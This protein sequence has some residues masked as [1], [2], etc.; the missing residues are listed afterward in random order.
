MTEKNI[1][2][3][4][5]SGN[6]KRLHVLK[7]SILKVPPVGQRF[8]LN[9]D[10][11]LMESCFKGDKPNLKLAMSRGANANC[12]NKTKDKLISGHYPIT[13]ASQQGHFEIVKT[14]I[15]EYNVNVNVSAVSGWTALLR[16]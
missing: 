3:I 6:L 11:A 5:L 7:Y 1:D 9:A 2:E 15:E 14:I 16:M 8:N 12:L 10:D 13:I 4:A